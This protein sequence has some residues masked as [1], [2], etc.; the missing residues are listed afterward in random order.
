[1]CSWLFLTGKSLAA[2][3][4]DFHTDFFINSNRNFSSLV[5]IIF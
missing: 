2:R 4:V 5:G 1:M 3:K